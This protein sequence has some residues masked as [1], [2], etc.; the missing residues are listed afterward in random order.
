MS[1][2]YV[3]QGDRGGYMRTQDKILFQLLDSESEV[4]S[5]NQV[6]Q[7]LNISRNTVWKH[8]RGL[9]ERGYQV[10]TVVGQGYHLKGLP[11]QIDPELIR[12]HLQ[13][14]SIDLPMSYFDQV[15]STNDVAK[16]LLIK[17]PGQEHLIIAEKQ[18]A[19]RGRQGRSFYSQLDEGLYF[20]IILKTEKFKLE[21]I[22]LFTLLAALAM[23]R[24]VDSVMNK[25]LSIKWVNDLFY[26]GKKVGGI[27]TETSTNFENFSVDSVV[28]G[29]GLNIRGKLPPEL[30]SFVTTLLDN[31]EDIS[32]NRNTLLASFVG[33]LYSL[34]HDGFPQEGL[35]AYQERML[36]IGEIVG[37]ETR[38]EERMGEI[39]GI[40]E[41]GRLRILREGRE[42]TYNGSEIHFNSKS[43]RDSI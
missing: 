42:E 23:T 16:E 36:G 31:E 18:T 4:I 35:K 7:S 40:D 3:Y 8:I 41:Q 14:Y 34:I 30:D 2:I 9:E 15:E 5:G 33:H 26:Q 39:L 19:G 28:I 10:E 37:Y 32:F 29:V 38:D 13:D 17:N 6:A 21:E 12:Y 22:Q 24:A 25:E 43:F 20:S 1:P 11:N 27:L